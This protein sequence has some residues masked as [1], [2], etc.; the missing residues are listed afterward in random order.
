MAVMVAAASVAAASAVAAEAAAAVSCSILPLTARTMEVSTMGVRREIA[1]RR[2]QRDT[3]RMA[4]RL[5]NLPL[6]AG[7]RSEPPC[8]EEE[9]RA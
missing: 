8:C 5:A 1:A 4:R 7:E 2:T 3:G 9:R 6:R